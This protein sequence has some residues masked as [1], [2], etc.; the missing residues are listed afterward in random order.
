MKKL[1]DL[2][3]LVNTKKRKAVLLAVL[4]LL[5]SLADLTTNTFDDSI[6]KKLIE[7]ATSIEVVNE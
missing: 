6:T 7:L 1:L 4:A 3:K 5:A 2:I